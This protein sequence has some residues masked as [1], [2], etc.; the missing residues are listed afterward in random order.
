MCIKGSIA[1]VLLI[2][3]NLKRIGIDLI[4]NHCIIYTWKRILVM[5]YDGVLL[6]I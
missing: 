5:I 6:K 1:F 4:K 3:G 2:I